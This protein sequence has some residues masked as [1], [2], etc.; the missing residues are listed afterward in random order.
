MPVSRN[1]QRR[2]RVPLRGRGGSSIIRCDSCG[3]TP[4]FSFDPIEGIPVVSGIFTLSVQ[5]RLASSHVLPGCPPC[6]RLHGHT[7]T[8]RAFWEFDA[9]DE[10]G[11][12][13][14]F[15]DLKALLAREIHD[16]F[17]HR[18]LNDIAPFDRVAPTAENLA[19]EVHAIL[20]QRS[21][22][23]RLARVEVWEGPEA[24]AAYAES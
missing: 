9:L 18:H 23:G 6:D 24:C 10:F 21:A 11:M 4:P 19:R 13:A 12:G 20:R 3:P 5:C 7:W 15:R 8:V 1:L 2:T 14:N 17:D 22:A 16:K